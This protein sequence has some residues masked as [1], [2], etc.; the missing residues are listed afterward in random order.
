M[1]DKMINVWLPI[2]TAPKGVY[3]EYITDDGYVEPPEILMY[4]PEDKKILICK[5]SFYHSPYG[6]AYRDCE[7]WIE[8]ETGELAIP[9]YGNPT[10]WMPLPPPP[11]EERTNE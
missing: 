4:F 5:Y 10:Y 1:A 11:R 6:T 8:A 7:A 2:E 9:A 3:R